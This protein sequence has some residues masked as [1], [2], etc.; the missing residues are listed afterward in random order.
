M[1][2]APDGNRAVAGQ[3]SS[4]VKPIPEADLTQST[5]DGSPRLLMQSLQETPQATP[6]FTWRRADA[7][8]ESMLTP[9]SGAS[10]AHRE[11][12]WDSQTRII[13]K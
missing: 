1:L 5:V 11:G 2:R 13:C 7:M 9:K 8:T 3:P 4:E 6:P 12:S 10:D